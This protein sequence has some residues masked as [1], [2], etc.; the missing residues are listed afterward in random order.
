MLENDQL[1]RV[2][3]CILVQLLETRNP[4]HETAK[5]LMA[6]AKDENVQEIIVGM[7][8]TLTGDINDSE[9]DGPQVLLESTVFEGASIREDHFC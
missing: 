7:P 1:K 9:T 3:W 6:I 5:E 4:W 8:V 2:H